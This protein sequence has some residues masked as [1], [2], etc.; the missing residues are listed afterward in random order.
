MLFTKQNS[1]IHGRMQLADVSHVTMAKALHCTSVKALLKLPQINILV[2]DVEN[3]L[4][5]PDNNV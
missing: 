5:T 3:L 1:Y 4:I 2:H